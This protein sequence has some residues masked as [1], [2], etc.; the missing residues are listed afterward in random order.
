MRARILLC[1]SDLREV[2]LVT[3]NALV[4]TLWRILLGSYICNSATYFRPQINCS[5]Q[6]P[7]LLGGGKGVEIEVRRLKSAV[8]LTVSV[9]W[10]SSCNICLAMISLCPPG[11]RLALLGLFSET[12]PI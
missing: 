12:L 4:A 3:R 10:C 9:R 11:V 2:K 1:S 5:G 7:V 8:N 6:Q